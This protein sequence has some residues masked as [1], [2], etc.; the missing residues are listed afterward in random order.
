MFELAC[1]RLV[2]WAKSNLWETMIGPVAKSPHSLV[3]DSVFW[4]WFRGRSF[5]LSL[6]AEFAGFGRAYQSVRAEIQTKRT[7]LPGLC[8]AA[9]NS[10]AWWKSLQG[11]R[12]N[13]ISEQQRKEVCQAVPVN[14][15]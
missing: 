4:V 12:K 9:A 5:C 14:F 10:T 3:F 6:R 13:D 15:S 8:G 2:L 11:R 7:F 1:E